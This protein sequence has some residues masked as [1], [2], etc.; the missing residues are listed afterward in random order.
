MNIFTHGHA[1]LI[2][3]GEY[4]D[5]QWRAPITAADAEALAAALRDPAVAAYPADQV[6]LLRDAAADRAGILRALA[7]FAARVG[8]DDPALI[9]FCGHGAPGTDEQYHFASQDSVFQSG[10][11]Q[12]GSGISEQELYTAL[13]AMRSNK[14]LVLINACFSGNIG[15]TLGTQTETT[16]ALGSPTPDATSDLLLASGAGRVVLTASRQSQYSYFLHTRE[17]TFFSDALIQGLRGQAATTADFIGIFELYRYLYEEV[18]RAA[19][20]IGR[21][22]EPV[23]NIVQGVGPFPVA[24]KPAAAAE[25]GSPPGTP[26]PG[27]AVRARPAELIQQLADQAIA[28]RTGDNSPVNIDQRGSVNVSGRSESGNVTIGD[29]AGGSIYHGGGGAGASP[30][31]SEAT[32]TPHAGDPAMQAIIDRIAA[33]KADLS[34]IANLADADRREIEGELDRAAAAAAAGRQRRLEMRLGL[35]RDLLSELA[36]PVGEARG[37]AESIERILRRL[38]AST[39]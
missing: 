26:P 25:L 24:R 21:E 14:L 22:Q 16:A 15:A 1:L 32:V 38:G 12:A 39:A 8:P 36:S 23:L 3:V 7:Q 17:L 10:R 18:R 37:L 6:T 33:I 9:F 19:A 34:W 5:E 20:A 2:G 30:P 28:V 29:V 13:R 27:T 4:A 11:I 31:P 35:A